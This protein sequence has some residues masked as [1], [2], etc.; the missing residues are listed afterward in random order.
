MMTLPM[1]DHKFT[2]SFSLMEGMTLS[3][4][5][6]LIHP[7]SDLVVQIRRFTYEIWLMVLKTEV[8]CS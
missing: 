2:F 4:I 8:L 7:K 1:Q 5:F 3:S 6:I